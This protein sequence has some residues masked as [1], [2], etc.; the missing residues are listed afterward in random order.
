MPNV[1]N[2]LIER[3]SNAEVQHVFGCADRLS[4]TFFKNFDDKLECICTTD[5]NHAGIAADAYS[6]AK[7]VGCACISGQRGALQIS[8]AVACAYAEHSPVIVV[9]CM[10]DGLSQTGVFKKITCARTSLASPNTAGFEIDRVLEEMHYHK[11]PVYIELLESVVNKPIAYDVYKQ[12]TPTAPETVQKN[13]DEALEEVGVMLAQSKRPLIWAGVLVARFSL[14]KE[15]EKFV[16]KTGVPVVT[17]PLS[18]SAISELHA[19]SVGVCMEK[20]TPDHVREKIEESDCVIVLGS[21]DGLRFVDPDKSVVASVGHVKVK[22]HIYPSVGFQD[23]VRALLKREDLPV[24][25]PQRSSKV[26]P[27][28]TPQDGPI[29]TQRF[30]EKINSILNPDLAVVVD[31]GDSLFGAIDLVTDHYHFLC[32]AHYN[33]SGFA[34]PGALGAQLA[35]P[36]V[37]PLVLVGDGSFQKSCNELGT[38]AG[39]GLNPI[40]LVLNNRSHASCRLWSKKDVPEIAEWSY[41]DM[42][43][44]VG[45]DGIKVQEEKHLE[46]ALSTALLDKRNLHIINVIVDKK[47]ISP[48]LKRATEADD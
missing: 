28:F 20:A 31:C 48:A 27:S 9:G 36:K 32:P 35:Q 13:L 43:H 24:I 37:R 5:E 44:V 23:F 33:N 41:H 25:T 14:T 8:S 46:T 7:G 10:P 18:K 2:F 45:G 15:L 34:I 29:T 21:V 1:A 16:A 40:V 47:D 11:Q 17:T 39:L 38:I 6:R 22:N 3:I 4:D 42:I 30:F 12:G 26:R 19:S